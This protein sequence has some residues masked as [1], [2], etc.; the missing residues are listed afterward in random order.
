[1]R[2]IACPI[3]AACALFQTVEFVNQRDC[4]SVPWPEVA[5]TVELRD[6]LQMTLGNAYSLE[7]ELPGGGMSRVFVAEETA[8]GRRV[9]IKVMP[10][11]AA[12]GVSIER[13]KRE[14]ALA[15]RL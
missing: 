3:R 15:A 6:R 1:M 2:R 13:F 7:R 9:V 4:E 10:P 8:L 11:D 14:I 5:G 12:A